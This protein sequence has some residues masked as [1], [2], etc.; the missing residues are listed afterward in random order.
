MRRMF[1]TA[2]REGSKGIR[3]FQRSI[4]SE[5]ELTSDSPFIGSEL[6]IK[7]MLR[8]FPDGE[9]G[10]QTFP[11]SFGRGSAASPK[12]IVRTIRDM[13]RAGNEIFAANYDLPAGTSLSTNK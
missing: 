9:L 12:N 11:R 7:A 5:I 1:R 6:A 3:T 4:L 13:I 8:A 2:F 10:I